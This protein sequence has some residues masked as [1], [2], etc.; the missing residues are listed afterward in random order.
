MFGN[1]GT[2]QSFGC[3]KDAALLQT[4]V[5]LNKL[6]C[7]SSA[8]DVPLY[9][10]GKGCSSPL[11][12]VSVDLKCGGVPSTVVQQI[13]LF[14]SQSTLSSAG[15]GGAVKPPI[16]SSCHFNQG[17]GNGSEGGDPGKSHPHGDSNDETGRTPGEP[18]RPKVFCS[19]VIQQVNLFVS[20]C[21]PSFAG[22]CGSVTPVSSAGYGGSVTPPVTSS[23]HFNQGIG[24]GS[25]GGDPGKSHPHGS[26]NDETGRTP[27]QPWSPKLC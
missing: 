27:G 24:N 15:Y 14:V 2:S 18:W 16:S 8:L 6:S 19:N 7:C 5:D 10:L 13:N 17:L 26:S 3:S 1:N 22:R 9:K 11:D 25:E 20:R 23:C 12:K 4:H 21:T